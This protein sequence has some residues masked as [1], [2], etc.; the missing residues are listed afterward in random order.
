M[1]GTISLFCQKQISS[2]RNE[3]ST[4]VSRKGQRHNEADSK[5]SARA[6]LD[7]L[8]WGFKGGLQAGAAF[9]FDRVLQSA[10][11]HFALK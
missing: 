8:R 1:T 5:R 4:G 10:A 9:F 3:H 7:P 2:K 11:S 6:R